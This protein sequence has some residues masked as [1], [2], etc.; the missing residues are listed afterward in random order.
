MDYPIVNLISQSNLASLN[1]RLHTDYRREKIEF[2][3]SFDRQLAYHN[4][5]EYEYRY[6]RNY[7]MKNQTL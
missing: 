7:M 2:T 1:E 3:T 6:Y 4:M 5:T